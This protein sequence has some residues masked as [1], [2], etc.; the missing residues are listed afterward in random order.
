[1]QHAVGPLEP[2]PRLGFVAKGLNGALGDARNA[3]D[4]VAF[5]SGEGALLLAALGGAL[6]GSMMRINLGAD[7]PRNLPRFSTA[8]YL[9]WKERAS[10]LSARALRLPRAAS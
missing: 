4:S 6:V 3:G 10:A 1:V 5:F 9:N 2:F 8:A 7:S